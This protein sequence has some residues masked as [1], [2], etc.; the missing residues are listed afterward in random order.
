MIQ[1]NSME[2][3]LIKALSY[4]SFHESKYISIELKVQLILHHAKFVSNFVVEIWKRSKAKQRLG[5]TLLIK[6]YFVE[7]D[8]VKNFSTV[9]MCSR[10]SS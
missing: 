7:C 3:S 1:Y 6:L 4:A 8:F 2:Y 10:E 5:L 9:Q